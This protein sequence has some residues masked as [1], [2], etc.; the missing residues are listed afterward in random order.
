MHQNLAPSYRTSTPDPLISKQLTGP[1]RLGPDTTKA[2]PLPATAR[3]SDASALDGSN[4]GVQP[5]VAPSYQASASTSSNLP[6][7]EQPTAPAKLGP[8]TTEA[9]PLPAYLH[10]SDANEVNSLYRL[11]QGVAPPY[12]TSAPGPSN[13]PIFKE[14]PAPPA[15]SWTGVYVG[16]QIGVAAGTANFANP[17][18]SSIFGDGVITPVFLAGGQDRVQLGDTKLELGTG[19]RGRCEL[20]DLGWDQYLLGIFRLVCLSYLPCQTELDG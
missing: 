20:V 7:S 6:I 4:Y 5:G 1:I 13:L 2:A 17:L 10:A 16:G 8:D 18:G 15:W 9:A 19:Y 11:Q 14:P 12:Q 3:V